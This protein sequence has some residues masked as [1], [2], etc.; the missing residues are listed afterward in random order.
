MLLKVTLQITYTYTWQH[1]NLP[2]TLWQVDYIE[3]KYVK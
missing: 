3:Y 1:W 2:L